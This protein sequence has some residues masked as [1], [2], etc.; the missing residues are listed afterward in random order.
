MR[1]KELIK[2]V[3]NLTSEV[4]GIRMEAKRKKWKK[5]REKE[6]R[7]MLKLPIMPEIN[8]CVICGRSGFE[9]KAYREKGE[10]ENL[11]KEYWY[12]VFVC[13]RCLRK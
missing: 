11:G 8:E 3:N 7:E 13:K 12:K 4:K 9:M 5:E 6:N 1:K 2:I 10:Y